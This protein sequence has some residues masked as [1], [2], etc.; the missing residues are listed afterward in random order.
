M[1]VVDDSALMRKLLVK[2]LEAEEDIEVVGTA[3]D[4][5]FALEKIEKMQPDVVTL[6]LE[7]PR[8]D[9]VTA[10]KQI[11]ERFQLPV[12]L[13]SA[14]TATGAAI[15]FEALAAGGVDFVTKPERALSAPLESLGAELVRKIRVAANV[16][17]KK[18]RFPPVNRPAIAMSA[19]WSSEE[20]EGDY[21]VAIGVSTGGPNALSYL[22]PQ[23]RADFP[24]ALL[25]VQHMPK[26]FTRL[27]A[28]RLAGLCEI[29]VRE[30]TD[31]EAIVPGKALVAPGGHHLK[32]GRVGDSR[33]AS[34]SKT[35]PVRGLRP[36]V[37]ILFRS[38][39]E[40]FGCESS[41]THHDRNGRRRGGRYGSH[42]SGGRQDPG[43]RSKL[44]GRLRN[45]EAAIERGTIQKVLP[46]SEIGRHLN[47]WS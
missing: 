23:I 17:V 14:H 24:A 8:M 12:V 1:L 46:L 39:A 31:G 21:V 19:T 3:M 30:A 22:L 37:D 29:E 16:S 10:L 43:P 36:S 33:V 5:I 6:D 47:F 27:F 32:V 4:G 28:Q 44:L 25:I 11:V 40:Q 35:P 26:D 2:L 15:T 34:L 7:M 41:W 38:V 42:Q 9:G 45:A 18:L 13:V 20:G